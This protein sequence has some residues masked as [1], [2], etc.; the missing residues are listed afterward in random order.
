MRR[1]SHRQDIL[2]DILLLRLEVV[3]LLEA[4]QALRMAGVVMS[5]NFEKDR[6]AMREEREREREREREKEWEGWEK[7]WFC[8]C[9]STP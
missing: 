8:F 3:N 1:E 6:T 5:R 2:V 9:A 7:E 4:K